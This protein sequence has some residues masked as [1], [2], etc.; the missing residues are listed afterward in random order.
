MTQ[1]AKILMAGDSTMADVPEPHP[2]PQVGWGQAFAGLFPKGVVDNRSIGGR[3][4]LS[5]AA[6]GHWDRLVSDIRP[7]DWVIIQFGHNDQ[8]SADPARFTTPTGEYRANL[9]RFIHDVREKQGLPVLATSIA[10]RSFTEDGVLQDTHGQYPVVTREVG[11]RLEVPVLDLQHI[12]AKM[13]IDHG[14]EPSKKIFIWIA[15][16][17]IEALPD[18]AQDNTHLSRYGADLIA[19]GALAEARR[20]GLGLADLAK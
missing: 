20:L 15:K 19:K 17:D 7:G 2:K 16:G 5:F 13:I 18:G 10:R 3:S 8:K 6:Q 14:Q 11:D 12:S 1:S 9:V 4:T